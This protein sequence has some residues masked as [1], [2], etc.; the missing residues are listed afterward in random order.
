MTLLGDRD[1]RD[2]AAEPESQSASPRSDALHEC[3]RSAVRQYLQDMGDHQPEDLYQLVLSQVEKPLIEEVL[4]WAHG[5]QCRSAS[6]LGISRG[7]L[8][9]KI[10]DQHI[11]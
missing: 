8:R 7:T 6:A 11:A 1:L 5:N 3:V 2:N 4:R 9:K 10:K